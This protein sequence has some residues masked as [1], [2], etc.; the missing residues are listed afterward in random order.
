MKSTTAGRSAVAAICTAAELIRRD[1]AVGA[2][3]LQLRLRVLAL[4]ARD[5]EQIRTEHARATARCTRSRHRCSTALM[6]PRAR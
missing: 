5:D 3:A 1:H 2:G 4:D 6:S